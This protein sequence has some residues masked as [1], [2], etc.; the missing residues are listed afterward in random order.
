VIL[1][2]S[3]RREKESEVNNKRAGNCKPK[4]LGIQQISTAKLGTSSK[5][6]RKSQTKT[7]MYSIN[8]P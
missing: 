4:R 7:Y 3:S 5:K 6:R 8:H 2:S 1:G